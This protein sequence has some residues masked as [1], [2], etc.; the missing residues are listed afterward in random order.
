MAKMREIPECMLNLSDGELRLED[1]LPP[2]QCGTLMGNTIADF[3]G[4]AERMRKKVGRAGTTFRQCCRHLP[5]RDMMTW[6]Y[7]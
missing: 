2:K 7:L 6:A 5:R 4:T 3:D 1:L